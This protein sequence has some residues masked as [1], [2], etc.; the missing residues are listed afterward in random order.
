[1]AVGGVDINSPFQLSE[2]Y[3]LPEGQSMT[4][5]AL[6]IARSPSLF[7]RAYGHSR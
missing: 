2:L 7:L 3:S 5:R 1:V 6:R 4:L